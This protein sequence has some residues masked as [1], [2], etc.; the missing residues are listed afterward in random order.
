MAIGMPTSN[1]TQQTAL[2]PDEKRI[3]AVNVIIQNGQSISVAGEVPGAL[4][5]E[6]VDVLIKMED[7]IHAKEF[8]RR[9]M[10]G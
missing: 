6:L 9:G 4:I 10:H 8:K 7:Y 1:P 5:N 3:A 2:I